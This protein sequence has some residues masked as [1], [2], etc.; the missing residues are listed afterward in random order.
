MLFM[1]LNQCKRTM[2]MASSLI[3]SDI[4]YHS[5]IDIFIPSERGKKSGQDQGKEAG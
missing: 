2:S 3:K 1:L 5:V 4:T